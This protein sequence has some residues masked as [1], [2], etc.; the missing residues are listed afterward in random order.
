VINFASVSMSFNFEDFF[1]FTL[2]KECSVQETNVK[3][4]TLIHKTVRKHR[5]RL[6]TT[7]GEL[8]EGSIPYFPARDCLTQAEIDFVKQ[9]ANRR[10]AY[11]WYGDLW[12]VEQT[13][14]CLAASYTTLNKDVTLFGC[15]DEQLFNEIATTINLHS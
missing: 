4:H 11:Y 15:E 14:L 6:S 1:S 2:Q 10:N 9:T 3:H 5:E 8:S 13:G 7:Y 12:L